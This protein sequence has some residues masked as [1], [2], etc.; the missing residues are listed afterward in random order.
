[1]AKNK[2]RDRQRPSRSGP[3][4]ERRDSTTEEPRVEE[5][6]SGSTR[7]PKRLGHN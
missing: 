2:N 6:G 3:G 5:S 1:M 7:K 4:P